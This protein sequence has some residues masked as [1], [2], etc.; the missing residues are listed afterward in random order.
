MEEPGISTSA[1]G[2]EILPSSPSCLVIRVLGM[3]GG[4]ARDRAEN[5]FLESDLQKDLFRVPTEGSYSYAASISA[6]LAFPFLVSSG[7]WSLL[8]IFYLPKSFYSV[9]II[10]LIVVFCGHE[11]SCKQSSLQF[12][13]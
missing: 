4:A 12:S 5:P 11:F 3:G 13:E 7:D 6:L 1:N 10:F 2:C 9:S 8:L